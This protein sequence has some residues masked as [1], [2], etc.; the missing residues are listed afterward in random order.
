[1]ISATP[2]PSTRALRSRD[3]SPS[4][5]PRVLA[6]MP[7]NQR[8]NTA[9]HLSSSVTPA[10]AN[11]AS[12]MTQSPYIS[13]I[14]SSPLVSHSIYHLPHLGTPVPLELGES[15]VSP[16]VFSPPKELPAGPRSVGIM[17][18]LSQSAKD[19]V[20]SARQTLRRKASSS[21]HSRRDESTGPITRRRSDSKNAVAIGYSMD[22][23]SLDALPLDL[24][25]G[26]GLYGDAMSI[27]SEPTTLIDTSPE[28]Q[29]P[30]V[31]EHLVA[32]CPLTKITKN[33][34]Q[35]KLFFMDVEGSR[36]S[37]KGAVTTKVFHIDNIK[38]IRSGEEAA[39]FQSQLRGEAVD[40]ELCFTIN[41]TSSDSAKQVKSLHLVARNHR[42][43]RLWVETLESLAKHREELMMSMV[44]S[45]ER[46]SVVRAHWDNEMAKQTV[47]PNT[48]KADGLDLPAI[49]VLCRKLHIHIPER[50]L[51]EHFHSV[52]VNKSD[53]LDY[54]QFRDFLRRLRE[55]SDIRKIFDDVRGDNAKGVSRSQFVNFL[56]R[57]QGIDIH[58]LADPSVWDEKINDLVAMSFPEDAS[59]QKS[60]LI[61][62]NA[63]ASFIVSK[64]CHVYSIPEPSVPKFDQP[65]GEYFI[66][67]SHNTYLT[68]WQVGGT[69]SAET[70][71]TA[72]RHG[73]RC[74][75]IDCWNG[76]DGQP[77]VTHG[78]T[79]TSSVLF[80]DCINAIQRCA[81]DVSPYPVIISLEVHCD[82][83]Q[84]AKMV[85]IMND[86]F[87]ERLL[88][89]PLP[90]FTTQL[91]S[92]EDL[93]YKIL[94]KVK[95]TEL[96][97]DLTAS[98]RPGPA[99]R[100]RSASSPNRLNTQPTN[101]ILPKVP[102]VSSPALVTPPETI[103][104]PTDR[105]VTATS[106]SSPDEES[107]VPPTSP[108]TIENQRRAPKL[109][110]VG[111]QLSAL[112]VY[113]KGYTLRD[114]KDLRFQQYN[115]IFSLN[116][117]RA[118]EICRSTE[119]KALF[120][121]HNLHHLCRV[122]PKTLRFQSSNFDP[123]TFWRR[124]VQMVALNWQ[125]FD[126]HMQMN[127]AMFAAGTDAYGYVL[128]PDYLRKPRTKP[129]DFEHRVKLPRYKIRFSVQVI[130]AQ[131][132]PRAT[133]M[134]KDTPLNP[135]IEVQMFSAEDRARG[136]ANGTGGTET[137]S[138]GYHGIGSPYRRQTQIRF[139]NGYNPQF[140]EN[141]EL[142][143]ETKY[144][145]LVFVRFIVLNSDDGRHTGKGVRQLAAFTAK[146]GSLQK[147]YRH[148]PLFNGQGEEFIFSTLFCKIAKQEPKLM[149][150]SLQD[151]NERTSRPNVLR[152]FLSRGLSSDRGRERGSSVEEVDAARR[153]NREI[154]EKVTKK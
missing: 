115:H 2:S 75:E 134:G 15:L 98:R 88:V 22:S 9:L 64:D 34:K 44:G 108:S 150:W 148:L 93:K 32:G 51:E 131:Q 146:L 153:S 136:I 65:L 1:M 54:P 82:A 120:E 26:L 81:F 125:T 151:V 71:L 18:K 7:S 61:D 86:V 12:S 95:S 59:T 74:V 60:G 72:L 4:P 129:G 3:N 29:A 130:S 49:Q 45:T 70:Y 13:S 91:P 42:D 107:D 55:R 78:R 116:E 127:Q 50:E 46:E 145:E 69:A 68:G 77:R 85:H 102:Y 8:V 152:D 35:E 135:F 137:Y 19:G 96:H 41:Y 58:S 84:Q 39:S 113:M 67:S 122:Y 100:D 40:P 52:D 79:R 53:L 99:N 112:G 80:S 92:P 133:N 118:I 47:K 83:E 149:P 10:S 14:Q 123:N 124:G 104:S 30:C 33:K 17:R 89:Y 142:C 57:H 24:Q 154:E 62:A 20:S 43:L 27:S 6:R 66:S 76:Q 106:D 141:I 36:V 101:W 28:G 21:A 109:S 132:L 144:P 105:S 126:A 121:D 37:W 94:I 87:G 114:A 90:G 128:K 25:T 111:S 38:S 31:P 5:H 11:S 140:G 73:C 138:N 16:H 143:L 48:A 139:G 119:H 63:F 97:A 103:Y 23:P 110:K 56:K 117:N 147:G